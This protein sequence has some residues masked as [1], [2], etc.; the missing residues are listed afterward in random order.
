MFPS[1]LTKLSIWNYLQ[2]TEKSHEGT[3]MEK[4]AYQTLGDKVYWALFPKCKAW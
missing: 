1:K 4:T 3:F 2:K